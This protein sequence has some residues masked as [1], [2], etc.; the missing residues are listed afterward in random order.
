[1]KCLYHNCTKE[2]KGKG[3]FCSKSCMSIISIDKRR[4]A[5]RKRAKELLGGCCRVCQYDA[6]DAALEF[7]H[8]DPNGKEWEVGVIFALSWG[9]ILQ[10]ISKCV[11]VCNRCHR[12]I[13]CGITP[14]PEIKFA[15]ILT[16]EE[17]MKC[18][19]HLCQKEI[20]TGR[21]C[22]KSC[23]NKAHVIDNFKRKRE[24]AKS[25]LGGCCRV[26]GY[27]KCSDA[28]E[29]HHVES[30]SK[31]MQVGNSFNRSWDLILTEIA[32]CVLVCNRCHREIHYDVIP[33]PEIIFEYDG[34]S[35]LIENR[36]KMPEQFTPKDRHK[37]DWPDDISLKEMVWKH[38][39]VE[40]GKMLGVSY[41]SI[42]KRCDKRSIARPPVGHWT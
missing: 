23:S 39:L 5:N 7:H 36:R 25:I 30:S 24:K 12:E 28:L 32:K 17:I 42:A 4:R 18:D 1:M 33:C 34:V 11:L 16:T 10:E 13:H 37:I 29:F 27:N 19:H 41:V 26:C 9:R 22:S 2:V 8:V 3:R 21:F 15:R 40:L 14:C 6:C 20:V 38:S 31:E 35:P